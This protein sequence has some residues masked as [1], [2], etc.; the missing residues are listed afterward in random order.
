MPALNAVL[1]DLRHPRH[2]AR[3]AIDGREMPPPVPECLLGG[4]YWTID[5][6]RGEVEE[7]AEQLVAA[8]NPHVQSALDAVRADEREQS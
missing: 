1:L 2:L 8:A 6:V 5:D 7:L 4:H 3:Y